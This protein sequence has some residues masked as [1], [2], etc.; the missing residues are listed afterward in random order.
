DTAHI[1][2]LSGRRAASVRRVPLSARDDIVAAAEGST[3]APGRVGDHTR[4]RA[5]VVIYADDD[6][7]EDI[8]RS[9]ATAGWSVVSGA[10][11]RGVGVPDGAGDAIA[12]AAQFAGDARVRFVSSAFAADRRAL[13][14]R[15]A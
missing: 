11:G 13:E 7:R 4:A 14:Q 3:S 5:R 12:I 6:V 10:G 1:V 2:R 8:A 9:F 15:V